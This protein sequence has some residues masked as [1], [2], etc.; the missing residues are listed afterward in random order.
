[1]LVICI[2]NKFTPKLVVIVTSL[3][4]TENYGSFGVFPGKFNFSF[5][6]TEWHILLATD[7]VTVTFSCVIA[8]DHSVIYWCLF[9]CARHTLGVS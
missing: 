7:E 3:G 6:I 2:G 8:F 5:F 1:M 9:H 4:V